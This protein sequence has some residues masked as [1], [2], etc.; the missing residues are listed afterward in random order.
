[1]NLIS[2][3]NK[4]QEILA[5]SIEPDVLLYHVTPQQNVDAI[6]RDGV[7]PVSYWGIGDLA[8]Y[9]IEAIQDEGHRPAV[10]AIKLSE[11]DP[12]LIEPDHPGIAEPITT[13]IDK[14]EEDVWEEWEACDGTWEDSLNIVGSVSYKGVVRPLLDE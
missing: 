8:D 12:S 14:S 1:M 4:I 5:E 13:A 7:K 11:L 2:I 6:Q 10:F 9:Y 3:R